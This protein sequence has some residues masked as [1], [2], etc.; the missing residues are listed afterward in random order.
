MKTNQAGFT[1]MEV[2]IVILIIGI[3]AAIAIPSYQRYINRTRASA[4]VVLS[5]PARLAVT[6]HAILN[7]GD[8]AAVNNAVLNMPSAQLV[9]SSQNVRE[10]NISGTS[11]NAAQV[12]AVLA[13][14]LGTLTWAGTYSPDTGEV[15]WGCTYPASDP[16]AQY[17]PKTCKAVG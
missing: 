12:V 15:N 10:I 14:D 5:G 8:L 17:A 16:V 6:E 11:A 3:L 4:A 9:G 7:N 13:D 1:L 2:L